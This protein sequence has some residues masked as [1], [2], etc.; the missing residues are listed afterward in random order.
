MIGLSCSPASRKRAPSDSEYFVPSLNTW[1]TSIACRIFTVLLHRGQ[2]SPSTAFRRSANRST[3]K[4]RDAFTPVTCVSAT[5]F[6]V[7]A[8]KFLASLT[9]EQKKKASFDFDDKHRLD[10]F[11][12][13]QQNN[14]TKK[15][16]RKGLPFEDLKEEQKKLALELLRT[17]T[18]T[19][20]Y[21]QATTIM[22]L[23]NILKETEPPKKNGMIRNSQWYF[24]S[25]FGTPSKTGKWGWRFEGHHLSVNFTIDRGQIASVF[26]VLFKL[27]HR[28]HGASQ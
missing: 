13:P 6:N 1:P 9:D 26:S 15:Y 16:T 12:T 25:I 14:E 4:S 17:G 7:A 21:N 24:V 28:A 19:S 11:F 10:W 23:E 20:G 18:S 3:W 2:G 8:D 22:S 27:Q 5:G